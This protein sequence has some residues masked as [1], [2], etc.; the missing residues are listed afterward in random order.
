MTGAILIALLSVGGPAC[1]DDFDQ[2][3][4]QIMTAAGPDIKASLKAAGSRKP[5]VEAVPVKLSFDPNVPAN[6]S[7]QIGSD[8]AFVW[9]IQGTGAT[10][11]HEKV[12]TRVDGLT[13]IDWFG[14]RVNT[15]GFDPD[16]RDIA[17][18]TE[19]PKLWLGTRYV[20][21]H[22]PLIARVVVLFH[23]A[24]HTESANEGWPHVDCPNPYN[25]KNGNSV[26][27][28][29]V[30][31]LA[32]FKGA[33][34]DKALGAYGVA[35]IMLKNI[36]RFCANCTGKVRMDAGLYGDD[37]VKRVIGSQAVREIRADLYP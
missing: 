16:D 13:Y 20:T 29:S 4:S 27:G 12:F 37:N 10:K 5:T 17:Y 26:S 24:W 28:I 7:A 18:V 15:I 33:C 11:L 35:A 31:K 25:D 3:V 2:D 30:K 9:T 22:R 32:G 19:G 1:A 21:W 8:L 34:D 36:Q 6:I 23:E 14:S